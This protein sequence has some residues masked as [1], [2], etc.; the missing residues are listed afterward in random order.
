M[1]RAIVR[2]SHN[3]S[4]VSFSPRAATF[5]PSGMGDLSLSV[6]FRLRPLSER[7]R[8]VPG[9]GEMGVGKARISG[10]GAR[11]RAKSREPSAEVAIQTGS[12]FLLS[13]RTHSV[14][15]SAE[16]SG[17]TKTEKDLGDF[18]DSGERISGRSHGRLG[19]S[20]SVG[21][22]WSQVMVLPVI[23]TVFCSGPA[24]HSGAD[25]SVTRG[26]RWAE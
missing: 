14:N 25:W 8:V 1:S 3:P 22:F 12:S 18:E 7:T 16:T 9:T 23:D 11:G 15:A 19:Q 24:L 2:S 4:S 20:H 21:V 26:A 13:V 6:D 17:A 10:P 5:G